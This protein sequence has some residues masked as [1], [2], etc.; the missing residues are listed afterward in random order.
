MKQ[1]SK[2]K[3]IKDDNGFGRHKYKDEYVLNSWCKSCQ[4]NYKKQHYSNNKKKYLDRAKKQRE[5]NPEEYKE[6][7]KE[8][9][10]KNKEYIRGK[11]KEYLQTEQGKAA[12]RKAQTTY[13][14]SSEY[15]LKQNARKKVLRAVKSGKLIKPTKCESC[16][17]ETA[18]EAH[19]SDYNKP[20]EVKWFCKQCHENTHHFNEG[21]GSI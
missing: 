19:H 3:E 7:L 20:L 18:L 11:Q 16:G 8:Y 9:Y 2:C 6:Y 5:Q 10:Q 14:N 4:S 15:S 21:H 12:V 17:K 1:C 13:R